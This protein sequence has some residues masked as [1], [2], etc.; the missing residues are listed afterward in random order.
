[1]R[2]LT[3]L[4]S[5][6]LTAIG[7]PAIV[8]AQS[9]LDRLSG[10]DQSRLQ[11]VFPPGDADAVGE[12]AK[13]I[14]RLQLIEESSLQELA[15]QGAAKDLGD[16]VSFDTTISR[17]QMLKVPESLVEFLELDRLYVIG[18]NPQEASSG[19]SVRLLIA[20]SLP[21]DAS[22]GD[23]VTGA[24]VV[25]ETDGEGGVNVIA[26]SRP[27]WFPVSIEDR[28]RRLLSK[29]GIDVSQLSEAASRS[30]KPLT[31][32]DST[33]FY[34]MLAA[35]DAV[36][37]NDLPGS[38]A[39]IQPIRLLNDPMVKP[40]RLVRLPVETV[41]ITRVSV[42]E[43][44]RR[45]QLDSDH[46]YQIDAMADLGDVIVKIERPAGQSG[47]A[48]VFENRFPVS[49]VSR[50]LP[51][52]LQQQIAAQHGD[53]AIQVQLRSMIQFEGFFYRLWSY[54]SEFMN[55]F[56]GGDQIA[57]LLVAADL[58]NRNLT[59]RDP[60]GV[61]WIGWIAAVV[62]ICG[63]VAIGLGSRYVAVRDRAARRKRLES[64]PQQ[65]DLPSV[66]DD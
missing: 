16:A 2:L 57:P 25:V 41:Q 7:F 39:A 45:R 61:R 59:S 40:G 30:R 6:W 28:G 29:A 3:L 5:T 34:S 26:V 65:I 62:V 36:D 15:S 64:V 21:Q 18:V 20:G 24:G 23:R 17:I 35:A 12:L 47:P 49:I 66:E 37:T 8:S 38:E 60:V 53:R 13:L 10:F 54:E 42:S 48:A 56:G 51:D 46:Y 19:G 63:I 44:D 43:P 27:S 55:R 58:E 11:N 1:M 9:A 4:L 31:A 14:Y 50:R 33:L 22:P 32:E 52:F